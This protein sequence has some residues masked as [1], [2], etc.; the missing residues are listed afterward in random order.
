MKLWKTYRGGRPRGINF[1][2]VTT[3][4][5]FDNGATI[6][7][8]PGVR[9]QVFLQD[10]SWSRGQTEHPE[11]RIRSPTK[12]PIGARF[13]KGSKQPQ[14]RRCDE[15]GRVRYRTT[16]VRSTSAI[17]CWAIELIAASAAAAFANGP[18]PAQA[19]ESR[20]RADELR[21]QRVQLGYPGTGR[22]DPPESAEIA[23]CR[24]RESKG[25]PGCNRPGSRNKTRRWRRQIGDFAF[26]SSSCRF[27]G[28]GN[29]SPRAPLELEPLIRGG[30]V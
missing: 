15:C 21:A 16:G 11:R 17:R 27:N 10:A 9:L 4:T 25:V 6:F 19:A 5:S 28:L 3:A 7:P 2:I 20:S 12:L 1:A 18:E 8:P 29:I 26:A 13:P 23:N 30:G 14:L 22:S 24:G